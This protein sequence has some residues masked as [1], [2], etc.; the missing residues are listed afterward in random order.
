MNMEEKVGLS[1]RSS[2]YEIY[3]AKKNGKKKEDLPAIEHPQLLKKTNLKRFY[4]C[5]RR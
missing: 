3:G 4:I 1:E 2:N 5:R